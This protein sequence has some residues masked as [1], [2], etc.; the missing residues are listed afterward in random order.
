M[1]ASS[2]PGL[3]YVPGWLAPEEQDS[4]LSSIDASEWS[5][6]LRCRVQ[7]YGHRY[8]YGRRSVEAAPA[9]PLPAWTRDLA[10]RLVR[11]GHMDR[12]ADQAIINEYRPGQGISAHVDCVPCFGPVVAAVSL[13]SDCVMDFVHPGEG[14]KV[15][16]PLARGSL[17]VMT[18]PA[19][20]TWRHAI[21]ARKSDPGPAG[22][23]PRGRRVSVTFRTVPAA[24]NTAPA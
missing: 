24:P 19:R 4:L 16:V 3:R 13:G 15:A 9:P 14:T 21:A 17:C 18:G 6:E 20:Y 7:H 11:E 23:V 22:R 10:A 8:D 2:V 12:E 5:S 1:P